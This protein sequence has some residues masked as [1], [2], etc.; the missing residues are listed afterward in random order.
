MGSQRLLLIRTF[1]PLS[2]GGPVPP[3]GLLY[4]ASSIRKNFGGKYELKLCDTGLQGTPL[5]SIRKEIEEFRPHLVG[6]SALTCESDLMYA[7][8]G[9]VKQAAKETIVISGGP[10]SV[11][12]G[13][14][15]LDNQNIDFGIVGEGETTIVRLMS[16]LE[17]GENLANVDGVAYRRN[18][19]GFMTK[20]PDFIEQ[21][22]ELPFPAWDL[23]DIKQY[24]GFS[25]WNG[26][27]KEKFYFPIITSRGCPYHCIYCHNIFGKKVRG[28]SPQNVFSEIMFLSDVY[29]AREFHII[30]D[31]FN[32]DS[33]RVKEICRLIIDSGM[34]FSFAFP[35][36][37][38]ADI[39]TDEL[40]GLLKKIGTY[41]IN[42]AIETASPRLQA[43]IKKNLEI[44]KALGIIKK[45]SRA[46]IITGGFFMLGFPSE[47]R[48]EM[49][50]T[51][52]VAINSDIDIAYFFKAVSYPGSELTLLSPLPSLLG[53]PNS[54]RDLHF[55]ALEGSC[56]EV[57]VK[58]LNALL[59]DA[60]QRFFLN[61]KRLWR[62]L[63]KSPR[64]PLFIRNL[65]SMFVLL[66]VA[67]LVRKLR[68]E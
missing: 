3:L 9:I 39:M 35:N 47:K 60:Q 6:L 27:I 28:R 25:N 66:L 16:A 49:A 18:G 64:K 14:R 8:A 30:D 11:V 19:K 38:R 68:E 41:K 22:D 36:G 29:N 52:N 56:S 5:E 65:F 67:F 54:F 12:A 63:H 32:F 51:V 48:E 7:V 57:P 1:K 46:G 17:T 42:Y 20:S 62:L 31:I 40:V 4:I 33:G 61:P 50:E 21:L 10:H 45:T 15:L 58:D 26:I 53:Y 2:A 59:L 34:N 44:E 13:E 55:Y 24:A 37:L 23:L 43:M